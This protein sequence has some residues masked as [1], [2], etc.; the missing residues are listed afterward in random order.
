MTTVHDA[1][2][3][4]ER[5]GATARELA[6]EHTTGYALSKVLRNIEVPLVVSEKVC[7]TWFQDYLTYL[8][9]AGHLEMQYGARIR[10][11]DPPP[12]SGKELAVWL[13]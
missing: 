4:E 12:V 11:I 9:N 8:D 1:A 5:Y 2:E 7:R 6:V 3:L 10:G 13:L